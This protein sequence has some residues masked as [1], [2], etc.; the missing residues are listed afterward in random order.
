MPFV[1]VHNAAEFELVYSYDGQVCENTIGV[2]FTADPSAGALD[3]VA[4]ILHTWFTGAFGPNLSSSLS[5]T[6]IRGTSLT[7]D[8]STGIEYSTGLPE[9]ATGPA[10]GAP[11]NVA[12]CVSFRT[13]LRG[14]SHRGRNY[15]CAVP[16]EELDH[17]TLNPGWMTAVL[18][19]YNALP[20]LLE[21]AGATWVVI[22]RFSGV[23]PIT[24]RPIPR[25]TGIT[26]PVDNAAFTDNKSDSQRRRL[27]GRG[28]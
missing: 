22:S 12:P 9:A 19:A 6:L 27:P 20:A 23:D 24:H 13:G 18:G 7:T 28:R 3:G 8:T 5:L 25:T 14:R 4:A 26:T 11:G 1:P 16:Q 2:Q 10:D 17:A 15:V 21:P